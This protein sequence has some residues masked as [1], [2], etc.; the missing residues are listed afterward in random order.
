MNNSPAKFQNLPKLTKSG[1]E[2]VKELEKIV[3]NMSLLLA[4][5]DLEA[6]PSPPFL[7]KQIGK[8]VDLIYHKGHAF[9]PISDSDIAKAMCDDIFRLAQKEK[10]G[11]DITDS[12]ESKDFKDK[13]IRIHTE[14]LQR[15]V[16]KLFPMFPNYIDVDPVNLIGQQYLELIAKN[17]DY[18]NKHKGEPLMADKIERRERASPFCLPKKEDVEAITRLWLSKADK[19]MYLNK[20]PNYMPSLR[21]Y[22]NNFSVELEKLFPYIN[23]QELLFEPLEYT[24]SIGIEPYWFEICK[25]PKYINE[26]I[27]NIEA[28]YRE[29][30]SLSLIEP[31]KEECF[32]DIFNNHIT[33]GKPNPIIWYGTFKKLHTEGDCNATMLYYLISAL[34]NWSKFKNFIED[35]ITDGIKEILTTHDRDM[36]ARFF[37]GKNKP[38]RSRSL[39]L[40][41]PDKFSAREIDT[42]ISP[43]R[44]SQ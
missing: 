36:I 13:I 8:F 6:L 38:I 26:R 2:A 9:D 27:Y 15:I 3:S 23:Q 39:K 37:T 10:Y 29:M 33:I 25:S 4:R 43:F 30:V 5:H 44:S 22:W 24:V 11:F 17:I 16:S 40:V 42:V 19:N 31:D 35:R 1:K 34:R 21:E 28:L 20:D 41:V 18:K 32:K 14:V 12:S 7:A